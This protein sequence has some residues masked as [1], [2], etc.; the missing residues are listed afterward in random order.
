MKISEQL[1]KKNDAEV[2]ISHKVYLLKI[3][4]YKNCKVFISIEEL[5]AII[6]PGYYPDI[7]NTTVK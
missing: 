5:M 7:E 3:M 6:E 4:T 1:Y 2:N